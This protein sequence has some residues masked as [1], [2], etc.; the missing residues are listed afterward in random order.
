[1]KVLLDAS[2]SYFV[3]AE[4][5]IDTVLENTMLSSKGSPLLL[6]ASGPNPNEILSGMPFSKIAAILAV[7]IDENDSSLIDKVLKAYPKDD[8]LYAFLDL[9]IS[10][11]KDALSL[12]QSE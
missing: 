7:T 2:Y 12:L 4:K 1:M 10:N 6:T 8:D 11:K 3:L 9:W 5:N